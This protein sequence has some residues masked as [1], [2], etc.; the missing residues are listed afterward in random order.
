M[1]EI[2]LSSDFSKQE[3]TSIERIDSYQGFAINFNIKSKDPVHHLIQ[4]GSIIIGD[5]AWQ[6]TLNANYSR[7]LWRNDLFHHLKKR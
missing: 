6:E 1:G 5:I 7:I 2:L 4:A 3:I